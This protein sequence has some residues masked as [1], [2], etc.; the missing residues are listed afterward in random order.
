[1]RIQ[2]PGARC[3]A[4]GTFLGGTGP[5]FRHLAPPA[6]NLEPLGGAL[7]LAVCL[8]LSA[9]GKQLREPADGP[10]RPVPISEINEPVPAPEPRSPYGNHTPYTVLGRTYHVLP[11]SNGYVERG[12]AS[13][14]GSKFHGRSTSSGEIYDMHKVTAAHRSLPLPS[15]ATVRNLENGR[16][17]TVRV[18]DRGP[19]HSDRIV[20]LSYAAALKLGIVET[21][22]AEVVVRAIHFEGSHESEIAVQPPSKLPA[23]V[24]AGAFGEQTAA[25]SLAERLEQAAL[26]PVRVE[27]SRNGTRRVWRVRIGPLLDAEQAR[28]AFE[29]VISL[30][31][32]RP[33]YVYD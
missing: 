24:Q 15:F 9:C 13:W 20:D 8:L 23:R 21:G 11:T 25:A 29:G 31:L 2:V 33:V 26:G 27:P 14:Y 32:D 6:S 28:Q 30:G 17:I 22:T 12:Q 5:A 19:F 1:M 10:G 7:I 16:E 4:R 3:E 18:N